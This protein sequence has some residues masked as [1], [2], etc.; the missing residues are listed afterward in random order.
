MK[1]HWHHV[2]YLAAILGIAGLWLDWSWFR[3]PWFPMFCLASAQLA[4][5]RSGLPLSWIDRAWQSR[6]LEKFAVASIVLLMVA[7]TGWFYY[8]KLVWGPANER[9]GI[10]EYLNARKA[11]M[12][13]TK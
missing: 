8:V 12:E 2:W 11:Q 1:L 5:Y 7:I 10:Q 4:R 6:G 9:A 13:G 3:D